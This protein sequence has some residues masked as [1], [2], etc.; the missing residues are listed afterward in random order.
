M[1]FR[2]ELIQLTTDIKTGAAVAVTTIGTGVS[3]IF[4]LIPN[5]IGKLATVLGI[6]LTLVLTY[7]HV[8]AN[9]TRKLD[10]AIKK[11]ELDKMEQEMEL[12]KNNK[13]EEV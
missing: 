4:D 10:N 2:N 6:V 1:I 11:L 7:S 13:E 9:K 5:D 3:T 8:L 12:T